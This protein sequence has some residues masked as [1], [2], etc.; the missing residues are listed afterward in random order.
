PVLIRLLDTNELVIFGKPN[1]KDWALT[2]LNPAFIGKLNFPWV[3]GK[4]ELLDK[5]FTNFHSN[6]MY[7]LSREIENKKGHTV[8]NYEPK[9]ELYKDKSLY[10]SGLQ[11]LQQYASKPLAF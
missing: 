11:T 4:C 9:F 1:A 8:I 3:N 10:L 2:S 6:E 7:A 5:E